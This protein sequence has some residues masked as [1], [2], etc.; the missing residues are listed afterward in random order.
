MPLGPRNQW[1]THYSL[2]IYFTLFLLGHLFIYK[3]SHQKKCSMRPRLYGSWFSLQCLAHREN[4]FHK[5]FW[6]FNELRNEESLKKRL[7]ELWE[8]ERNGYQGRE[9][10]R[11]VAVKKCQKSVWTM[12]TFLEV[13]FFPRYF[14]VDSGLHSATDMINWFGCLYVV[15]IWF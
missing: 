2:V 9:W 1:P 10:L 11:D 15:C 12:L 5:Y 14:S 4:V 13:F 6:R 7:E 8:S 3:L